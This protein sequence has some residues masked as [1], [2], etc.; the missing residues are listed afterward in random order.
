[1]TRR[2][3]FAG[4]TAKIE[5]TPHHH[6]QVKQY[7]NHLA[8]AV[9]DQLHPQLV[10]DPHAHAHFVPNGGGDQWSKFL[11]DSTKLY[12]RLTYGEL[13]TLVDQF[14]NGLHQLGL[15]KGDRLGVWL[16]NTYHYLVAQA[17]YH[18]AVLT[19]ECTA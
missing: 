3:V 14:A 4:S 15:R 19:T 2:Y 10:K 5:N 1:L 17:T 7:P 11:A 18:P 13:A 6:H 16:P 12:A 8:V 9:L